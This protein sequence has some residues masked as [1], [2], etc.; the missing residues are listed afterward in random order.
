MSLAQFCAFTGKSY[1]TVLS[2][3]RT[4]RLAAVRVG[5]VWRIYLEEFERYKREGL[6]SR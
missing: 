1:P 3:V 5:G 4:E 2:W 6:L